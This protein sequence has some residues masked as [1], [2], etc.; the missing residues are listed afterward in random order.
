MK[1][2]QGS[3]VRSLA[4]GEELRTL[5]R[6]LVGQHPP[7][8]LD[9][10]R[11]VHLARRHA[12]APLLF[13]RIWEL[14]KDTGAGSLVPPEVTVG[15]QTDFYASG[16]RQLLA[17]QQ[18]ARVIESLAEVGI[19]ALVLKGAATGLFYPDPAT[20]MYGD[21][22]LLV[23]RARLAEAERVLRRLGFSTNYSSAWWLRHF[24]HLPIM[25]TPD[26]AF[27]VELHWRVDDADGVGRLPAEELWSR[28]VPWLLGGQPVLRLD[29]ID[30]ILHLC[31]HAAVQ[32]RAQQGLRPLC[33]LAHVTAGWSGDDWSGLVERARSHGLTRAVYLMLEL[34]TEALGPV[35]PEE[36]LTTLRPSGSGSFPPG[37]VR[38]LLWSGDGASVSV[39]V[40]VVQARAKE[41]LAEAFRH[42]LWHLF[43]PREGMA[44]VY[45]IPA[46]S[47]RIWLY[48]LWRPMEL[49]RRYGLDAWFAL[50][51]R[52]AERHAWAREVWLENWFKAEEESADQVI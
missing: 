26:D 8:T 15:L 48:Y 43:L 22:D 36:A 32:H 25:A 19:S 16:A 45:N 12:V 49:L 7:A 3:L 6:I 29:P 18:S 13:W 27:A 34:V 24:H 37:L 9:W 31:R 42:L 39:P 5:G 17:E 47:P 2:D 30:A 40:A 50:R 33:D 20:R 1:A 11:V 35:V 41:S 52:Q 14:E 28:A 51:G 38:S 10:P 23:P 44:V 21:L 4:D 46:D